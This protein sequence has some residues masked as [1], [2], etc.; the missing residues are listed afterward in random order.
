VAELTTLVWDMADLDLKGQVKTQMMTLQ[1]LLS[2]LE[3]R[4]TFGAS[5]YLYCKAKLHEV[6][7][8]LKRLERVT[9]TGRPH[10]AG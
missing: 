4:S 10:S 2:Y 6:V 3:E 7:K 8:D 9:G 1:G 5:E